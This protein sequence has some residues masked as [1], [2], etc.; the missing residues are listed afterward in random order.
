MGSPAPARVLGK[1]PPRYDPRTLQYARYRTPT[2]PA[3]P[4]QAHWGNNIAYGMLGNDSAGD[5]VEAGYAHGSQ[6]MCFRAG[7]PWEPTTAETIGSYS[8]LSGYVPGDPAT[9]NGT[10]MLSACGYWRSPGLAGHVINAYMQVSPQNPAEV[11]ESVAFYGGLYLG[12]ALPVAAQAQVGTVWQVTSGA[13]AQAGSWGGH[14]VWV[15]GYTSTLLW[16]CTWGTLQAMTWDWLHTYADEAYV[17]LSRDWLH[18]SGFSPSGLAWG[19][20]QAD[21]ANL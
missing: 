1:K 12:V 21:L 18:T 8:A 5:C 2:I 17:L 20:L 19:Q 6:I 9:D 4:A 16:C 10:D 15:T 14:C 3:I 13:D 7:H 11:A